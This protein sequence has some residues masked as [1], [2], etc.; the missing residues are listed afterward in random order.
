MAMKAIERTTWA[1]PEKAFGYEEIANKKAA[2]SR[3]RLLR[4][5]ASIRSEIEGNS[6]RRQLCRAQVLSRGAVKPLIVHF[7]DRL[8]VQRR[9]PF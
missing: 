8:D 5:I 7:L 6:R 2:P 9:D 3:C 1:F 4:L